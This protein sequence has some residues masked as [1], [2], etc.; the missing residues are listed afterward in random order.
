MK[1][2]IRIIRTLWHEMTRPMDWFDQYEE[3]AE[4]A[5]YE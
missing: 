2:I 4:R 3:E 5:K 1:T